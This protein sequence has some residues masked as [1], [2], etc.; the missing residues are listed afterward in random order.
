[1]NFI[2][3]A[4]VPAHSDPLRRR[5]LMSIVE[6]RDRHRQRVVVL[7]GR[8]LALRPSVRG[9]CR[10]APASSAARSR[11]PWRAPRA[12]SGRW[13]GDGTAG[14]SR[15]RR[16]PRRREVR[17]SFARRRRRGEGAPATVRRERGR[18]AARSEATVSSSLSPGDD[19]RP[20]CQ[21]RAREASSVRS[22]DAVPGGRVAS[23]CREAR[24]SPAGESRPPSPKSAAL[25]YVDQRR[26]F[27]STRLPGQRR[28]CRPGLREEWLRGGTPWWLRWLAGPRKA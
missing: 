16:C 19:A 3:R 4:L 17:P 2:D 5:H 24:I 26:G 20:L 11:L 25:G 15:W 13:R 27:R 8:S 21:G 7:A 10:P 9:R 12:R 14:R 18:S 22:G 1:M 6:H 28:Q 23:G